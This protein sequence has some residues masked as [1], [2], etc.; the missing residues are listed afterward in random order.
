MSY[1]LIG[2]SGTIAFQ[3]LHGVIDAE[4]ASYSNKVTS[5]PI[6]GGGTID[7]HAVSEPVKLSVSGVITRPEGGEKDMLEAMAK[8]RD[9]LIYRGEASYSDMLITS[10]A[11]GRS[12]GIQGGFTFKLQLQQMQITGAAFAPVAQ[13]SMSADRGAGTSAEKAPGARGETNA[14][15]VTPSSAYAE[16]VASFSNPQPKNGDIAAARSNPS[17][18]GYD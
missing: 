5:N 8:N 16:Y 12:S 15:L 9:L 1:Y 7:D 18:R 11:I 2:D 13:F 10:L 17:Y 6:E 4:D 3:P 14:G